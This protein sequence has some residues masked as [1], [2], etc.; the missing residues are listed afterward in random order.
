LK[1]E[2]R[3]SG[4]RAYSKA[5]LDSF[6]RRD[7]PQASRK[8]VAYGRVSSAAQRPDLKSQ[9]RVGRI[10][11]PLAVYVGGRRSQYQAADF[12]AIMDRIEASVR[13]W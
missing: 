13:S 8:A 2:R 10:S 6:M 3:P 4:R 5:L 9:R 1:P 12:V 7:L 11:T